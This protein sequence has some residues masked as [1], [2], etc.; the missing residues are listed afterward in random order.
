MDFNSI[1][2]SAVSG[3]IAGT[4]A[5]LIAPWINWGIEKRKIKMNRRVEL[6]KNCKEL[7]NSEN[8]D[9]YKFLNSSYYSDIKPYLNNE[10]VDKIENKEGRHYVSIVGGQYEI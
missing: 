3:L 7:I 5:S 4:I 2:V 8:F 10:L 1:I 9:N 6:I